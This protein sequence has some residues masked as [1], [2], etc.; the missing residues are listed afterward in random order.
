MGIPT[1]YRDC[2]G[3]T[4]YTGD[5]VLITSKL[6]KSFEASIGLVVSENEHSFIMGIEKGCDDRNGV[7]KGWKIEKLKSYDELDV[8]RFYGLCHIEEV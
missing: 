3:L 4:L 5:L 2:N 7:V 1:P 8:G 6:S